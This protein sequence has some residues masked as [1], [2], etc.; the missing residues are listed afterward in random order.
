MPLRFRRFS[1]LNQFTAAL[2]LALLPAATL[3]A[4]DNSAAVFKVRSRIVILDIVVTD[5][6]GNVVT[7]LK[8]SDFTVYEDKQ[9]QT[10]QTFESPSEH[11]L[12]PSPDGRPIVNSA[13]D[14]PK[15]GDAPVTIIVLDEL[16]TG[17]NDMS[18]GRRQLADYL[19][20]QPEILNQPTA[21]LV[22]DT[23]KFSVLHDYTQSRND[24]VKTLKAHFPMYPWS[25]EDPQTREKIGKN[26]I[27][28][29]ERI[30][31]TMSA[32]LQIAAASTG[33]HGRKNVVW[34]GANAPGVN[35]AGADPDVKKAL[36]MDTKRLTQT[37]LDDRITM[38]YIDP[39]IN[40]SATVGVIT[41]TNNPDAVAFVDT[42]PFNSSVNF[43]QF[44]PAT[45]GMV[46]YSRNDINKE[47]ATAINN[48]GA[49]YTLSY[50][51][52]NPNENA[53]KFRNIAVRLSDPGLIATTRTGYYPEAANADNSVNDKSLPADQRKNLLEFDLSAAATSTLSYNGLAVTAQKGSDPGVWQV[54]VAAKDLSWAQNGHAP[55]AEVTA[56][57]VTYD[58]KNK[59]LTHTARELTASQN[60]AA[61]SPDTVTFQ[62]PVQIPGDAKRIR[63]IIRDA[64]SGHIGTA[65]VTP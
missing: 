49:Y 52:S 44:G 60:A 55:H 26:G 45:G 17:Y 42:D 37:M 28:A 36:D 41:P 14:L 32:L 7:N 12:P 19:A 48:G 35:Y 1:L 22:V 57:S 9:P 15:I 50:R 8:Q 63:F 38:Y 21:L 33:T 11:A 10:I 6:K 56:M 64:V 29:V 13:A 20:T 18:F 24:L 59:M 27:A 54:S 31:Q 3:R 34:V 4:Q 43:N 5:K 23:K 65:D 16:N 53:A 25:A 30:A 39:T 47:I 62:V 2:L 51:P 40:D 61:T 58:A 46:L